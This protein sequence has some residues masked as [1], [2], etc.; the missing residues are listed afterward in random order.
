MKRFLLILGILVASYCLAM[1]QSKVSY[2]LLVNE[3]ASADD[4]YDICIFRTTGGE[5]LSLERNWK[6]NVTAAIN[7][8]A[9]KRIRFQ[10]GVAYNVLSL[11]EVN[12]ALERDAFKI[13]YLSIPVRT[14]YFITQGKVKL[15]TGLG[16]RTDIRV[17]EIPP[18]P[19]E[20][21]IVQDQGRNLAV[22]AE[23]LA[24]LEIAVLPKLSVNFEPTF[25]KGI[26]SYSRDLESPSL[27]GNEL[28]FFGIQMM[29]EFPQ[30]IG[31]TLGVTYGLFP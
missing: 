13:K 24:G 23:F 15:Y 1:A 12:E 14:H 7:Y 4:T 17:N 22:S 27:G 19:E 16:L 26:T 11:D 29:P 2:S 5:C 8:Q 18:A 28:S 21:Y 6:T 9:N 30:R 25:S 20:G 3:S 10:A 31:I